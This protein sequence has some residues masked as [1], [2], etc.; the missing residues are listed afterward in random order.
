[1]V[2]A[3]LRNANIVGASLGGAKMERTNLF[4]TSI[5][6]ADLSGATF[7]SAMLAHCRIDLANASFADFSGSEGLTPNQLDRCFGCAGTKLPE[8]LHP[9]DHWHPTHLFLFEGFEAYQTWRADRQA[10]GLPPFDETSN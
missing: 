2:G 3:N 1:M 8:G 6:G 10:K 7:E 9:P 5:V 4:N